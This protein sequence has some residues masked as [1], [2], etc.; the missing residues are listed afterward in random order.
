MAYPASIIVG[1][2]I[3]ILVFTGFS[4][5]HLNCRSLTSNFDKFKVLID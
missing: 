1:A 4:L 3:H 2:N 5:L